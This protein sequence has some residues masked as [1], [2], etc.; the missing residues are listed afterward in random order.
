[1]TSE[2]PGTVK[3]DPTVVDTPAV[4]SK[5][6]VGEVYLYSDSGIAERK[7]NVPLWLWLVAVGLSIWGI[8]Y[9]LMYWNPTVAAA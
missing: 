6:S 9:L 4:P 5:A 1:M 8:Y 7:G 2:Q 3:S